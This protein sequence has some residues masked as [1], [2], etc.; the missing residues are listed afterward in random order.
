MSAL[1][2]EGRGLALTLLAASGLTV[3][4]GAIVAP[5]LPGIRAAFS[6]VPQVEL[7]ARLVLTAPALA[8]ALLAPLAGGLLDRVGRRPVLLGALVLY[9][10]AGASGL[11]LP[12]LPGLLVGRAFLG[13]AVAGVM[14]A[15]TTLITDAFHGETR[16]RVLGLQAA[17]TGASGAVFLVLGGALASVSWRAPFAIYLIAPLLIPAVLALVPG[18]RLPEAAAPRDAGDTSDKPETGDTTETMTPRGALGM[19]LALAGLSMALLYLVPVQVPFL[20]TARLQAEGPAIGGAISVMT[21]L[22]VVGSVAFSR[23]LGLLGR[24]R[25]H[26]LGFALVALGF[27]LLAVAESWPLHIIALGLAGLGFGPILPALVHD[28]SEL[29]SETRRGAVMGALTA[30]LFAG[31]FVSPILVQP[32]VAN[33]GIG[34]VFA[35]GAGLSVLVALA[36]GLLHRRWSR[37]M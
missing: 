35:S 34:A 17:W 21:A 27:A 36:P 15:A 5:S 19:L 3:M 12:T 26:S 16:R 8:V 25:L 14:T 1:P 23:L 24:R 22:S 9:A 7:L 13:A 11:V 31:Q 2:K 28:A 29:A 37:A 30:S 32:L 4:A 6:G 10:L 33:G 20:L 18:G